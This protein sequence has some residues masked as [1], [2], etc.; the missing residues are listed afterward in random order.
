MTRL[1]IL[2]LRAALI[3]L[4][5]GVSMGVFMSMAQDFTIRPVHVHVNLLGW[6]GLFLYAV[7]YT[8][9]SQAAETRLAKAHYW[10]SILGLPTMMS[11]LWL[12]VTGNHALGLPLL[13]GGEFVFVVSVALFIVIGLRATFEVE[14]AADA[15]PAE[16]SLLDER[17][18]E[19]ITS[20]R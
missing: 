2:F 9:F 13:L 1:S 7:F 6:V 16:A 20:P 11:G 3:A 15:R 8:L 19:P 10:C 17:Y 18:S 14:A 5:V 12:V 4:G